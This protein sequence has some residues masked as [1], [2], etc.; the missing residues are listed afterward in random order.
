[1]AGLNERESAAVRDLADRLRKRLG[2]RL[3]EVRLYGSKA[4]R[5]DTA[6][7]DVDLSVVVLR[8]TPAIRTEV[9]EEVSAAMIAHDV[10]L[11]VHISDPRHLKRLRDIGSP[12]GRRLQQEGI[13]L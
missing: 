9:F 12:Y 8:H 10:F 6:E 13:L 4:R 11:D 7:S 5:T 3:V 1:M 2:K